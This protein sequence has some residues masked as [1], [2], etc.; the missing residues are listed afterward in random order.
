MLLS[1]IVGGIR[2]IDRLLDISAL[3]VAAMGASLLREHGLAAANRAIMAP[4][5]VFVFSALM[6]AGGPVATIVAATATLT[7]AFVARRA[8]RRQAL[9]ETVIVPLAVLSADLTH[10]AI[11]RTGPRVFL[12]PW[13]ALSVAGA[14]V[15]YHLVQGALASIVLPAVQRRPIDRTWRTRALAGCS[16][17]LLGAGLAAVIV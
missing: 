5:F 4:A 7:P 11:M 8:S 3:I 1:W 15:T 10:Q 9:I 13:L 6:L 17:Y 12:W 16:L 14:V 2:T